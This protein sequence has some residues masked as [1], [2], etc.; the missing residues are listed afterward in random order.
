ML[1]GYDIKWC[2]MNTM[3][4]KEIL[5][6]IIKYIQ[7]NSPFFDPFDWT[8]DENC[9]YEVELSERESDRKT[10]IHSIWFIKRGGISPL[11]IIEDES[12][13]Y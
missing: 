4:H 11:K 1:T 2:N 7:T 8:V 12:V 13:K 9:S 6:V 10:E 3:L 5:M